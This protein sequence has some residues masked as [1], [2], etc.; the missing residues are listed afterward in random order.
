MNP[1]DKY[2][3]Y[4]E[5]AKRLRRIAS[6]F[7][8]GGNAFIA[9]NCAAVYL[10]D[11]NVYVNVATGGLGLSDVFLLIIF[12]DTLITLGW[13]NESVMNFHHVLNIIIVIVGILAVFF[14]RLGIGG[15]IIMAVAALILLAPFLLYKH[16]VG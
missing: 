10:R 8:L 12:A 4:E 16:M 5:R 9:L 11:I 3:V 14:L 6:L 15:Y 13:V 1:D 7:R 2:A